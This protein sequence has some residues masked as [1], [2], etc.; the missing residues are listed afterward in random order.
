MS[1]LVSE[2]GGSKG[3]DGRIEWGPQER[4]FENVVAAWTY[5]EGAVAVPFGCTG[6]V[7]VEVGASDWTDERVVTWVMHA[8]SAFDIEPYTCHRTVE[9]R[10]HRTELGV[11][12]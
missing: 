9:M 10:G 1:I 4:T 6:S 11:E 7:E 8:S 5:C 3:I 12:W 2:S